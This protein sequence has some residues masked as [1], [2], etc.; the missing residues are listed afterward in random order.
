MIWIVGRES[1]MDEQNYVLISVFGIR[2]NLG[3]TI[4]SFELSFLDW[5]VRCSVGTGMA[6]PILQ[7]LDR[8]GGERWDRTRGRSWLCPALA[9]AGFVI[10]TSSG[11]TG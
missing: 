6:L 10:Q 8:A 3:E 11:N 9:A 7:E 2:R 1:G 4:L 5:G